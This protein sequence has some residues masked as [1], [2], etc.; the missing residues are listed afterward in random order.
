LYGAGNG[1]REPNGAAADA[2][3]SFQIAAE[4]FLFE[5]W[6]LILADEGANTSEISDLRSTTP[7]ASLIKTE[8]SQR[9]GGSWDT[10]RPRTP[11]G[12]YWRDLYELEFEW[13]MRATC[14]TTATRKSR[15]RVRGTRGVRSRA[16]PDPSQALSKRHRGSAP[17]RRSERPDLNRDGDAHR[18][19]C[20]TSNHPIGCRPGVR[21]VAIAIARLERHNAPPSI[22][23][24]RPTVCAMRRASRICADE[25]SRRRRP[26]TQVGRK[27]GRAVD[28]R[29]LPVGGRASCAG[30][31][32]LSLS[33]W[34]ALAASRIRGRLMSPLRISARSVW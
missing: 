25:G 2:V 23:R 1:R 22:G 3:V 30:E 26:D 18:C 34:M 20:T 33:S 10:T 14:R 24:V 5:L 21:F 9:L 4:A 31:F 16:A 7:F 15:T 32:S 11:I 29:R 28:S 17:T 8:L 27:G 6:A 13:C 12:H 19:A